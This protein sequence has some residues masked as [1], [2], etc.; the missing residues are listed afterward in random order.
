MN[1]TKIET[2][3]FPLPLSTVRATAVRERKIR[4]LSRSP[5]GGREVFDI[6]AEANEFDPWN[7]K[8]PPKLHSG[9]RVAAG[10]PDLLE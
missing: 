8:V 1:E 2:T 7:D 4:Q 9:R 5:G 3:L 10:G 6:L